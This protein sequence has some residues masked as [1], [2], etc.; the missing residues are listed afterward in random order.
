MPRKS[1]IKRI[2]QDDD[3]FYSMYDGGD[4]EGRKK[5]ADKYKDELDGYK[6]PEGMKMEGRGCPD[7]FFALIFI[8]FLGSMIALTYLGYKEG[9]IGKLIAP[10]AKVGGVYQLCGYLSLIHI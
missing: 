5:G 2:Q 6:A 9:D 10:V 7:C 8:C 4:G 1:I 3:D